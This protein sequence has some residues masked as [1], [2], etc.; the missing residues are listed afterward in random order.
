MIATTVYVLCAATAMGC[1]ILL[2]RAYVR[3]GFK[4]LFWSAVSFIG[5]SISNIL[6][7]IDLVFVP[8]IDLVLYRNVCTLVSLIVLVY[9]LIWEGN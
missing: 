3:S 5:L 9:S 6:L 1:A 4:L 2:S 8:Q 7:V